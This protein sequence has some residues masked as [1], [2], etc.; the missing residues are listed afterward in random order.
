MMENEISNQKLNEDSLAEAIEEPAEKK[1]EKSE[2]Q[3]AR[4]AG[5]TA[6]GIL[7][8]NEDGF[9]FLR[10]ANYLTGSNDVYV[11]ASQI[12]RF[13]LKTGDVVSG[14]VREPKNGEKFRGLMYLNSV[15]GLDPEVV[16]YRTP[17]EKLTPCFP[18]ERFVLKDC[19]TALRI[20][21]LLAPV[22]K[23]QRGL[24]VSP[25]KAGKTTLLKEFA[26]TIKKNNPETYVIV[27]LID[28]R[29]EE[30][31]DM[32][33][34][35]EPLNIEVIYSTFDEMPEKHKKDAE[36]T[37]FHPDNADEIFQFIINSI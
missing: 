22:G 1:E 33:E 3:M 34:V 28:E 18:T 24:I 8:I 16:K 15:N 6:S 7:E 23:G 31:T 2:I 32:K 36:M 4:E 35:C 29:P 5:N 14:Y 17:F 12:R 19:S 26:L 21:D 20:I 9:G 25:P 10:S 13:N 30:V 27:L 37:W 11:S